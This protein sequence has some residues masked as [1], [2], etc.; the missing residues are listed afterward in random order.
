MKMKMTGTALAGSARAASWLLW[1]FVG[2]SCL[3]IAAGLAS[4]TWLTSFSKPLLLSSLSLYFWFS[5]GQAAPFFRRALMAGFLFSIA[6]DTLLIFS[7]AEPLFFLLG[8]G[9][10]LLTHL[11]YLSAF[12]SYRAF[13]Q[14][15]L[16]QRPWL[17]LPFVLL[18]IGN[19]LFLWPDL[20][21]EM[22]FP[23][24]VYAAAIVSMAVAVFN[25][26]KRIPTG[27]FYTLIAGVLLFILSD[28]LIGIRQFKSG[29]ITVPQSHLLIMSTYL[30]G[31]YLIARAGISMSHR[32]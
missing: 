8:L 1:A 31:Q 24:T 32:R 6:G 27:T 16:Y 4:N 25:L 29:S 10:F 2:L 23:V 19:V 15:Y 9:S 18:F 17:L 26:V 21:A 28:T 30:A 20:S 3:H 5:S 12:G 11:C 22:A 14:G 7:D 13:R